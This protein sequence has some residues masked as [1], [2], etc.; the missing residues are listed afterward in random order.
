MPPMRRPGRRL[1]GGVT[2]GLGTIR[3][4]AQAVGEHFEV[5]SGAGRGTVV[6]VER[7]FLGRE[8]HTMTEQSATTTTILI[9]SEG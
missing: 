1:R 8:R 3:E 4:R 7:P 5:A 9:G 6:T 2:F